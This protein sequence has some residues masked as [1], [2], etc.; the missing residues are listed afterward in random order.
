MTFDEARLRADELWEKS[1]ATGKALDDFTSRFEKGPLNLTP[2]H[3]KA[4][5]EYQKL[6]AEADVAFAQLRNYNAWY[7]KK[8]KKEIYAYRTAQ[9]AAQLKGE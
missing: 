3:V 8:F 1:S 4:L 7:T 5:P 9:R 2:D 6:K